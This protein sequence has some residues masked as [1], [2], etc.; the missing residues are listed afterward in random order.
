QQRHVAQLRHVPAEIAVQQNVLGCGVDPLLAAQYVGDLHQVVVDHVGQVVGGQ[1][2]GLHQ[3]LHVHLF[4]GNLD[5]PTQ[6]VIDHADTVL[7]DLHAY[8]VGFAGGDPA[9]HL[10]LAQ[11]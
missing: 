2:V 9:A 11:V 6:H 1:T 4:P 8:H 3:H 7:G 10:V 5:L